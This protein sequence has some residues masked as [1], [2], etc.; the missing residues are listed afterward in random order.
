MMANALTLYYASEGFTYSAPDEAD[1]AMIEVF[2]PDGTLV[3]SLTDLHTDG[4][5]AFAPCQ[6]PAGLYIARLTAVNDRQKSSKTL[7]VM[8]K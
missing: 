6:L 5:A 1:T 3:A 2:A 8:V 7:K 4:Y